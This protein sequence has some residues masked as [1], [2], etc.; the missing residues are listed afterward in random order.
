MGGAPVGPPV[1]AVPIDR[2]DITFQVTRVTTGAPSNVD[3]G[4]RS[5]ERNHLSS[6]V[7]E[8]EPTQ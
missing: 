2:T 4:R 5:I 3:D 8:R 1:I 7:D 6:D